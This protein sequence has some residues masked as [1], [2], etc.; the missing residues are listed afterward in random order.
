MG[1]ETGPSGMAGGGERDGGEARMLGT[2]LPALPSENGQ[3]RMQYLR[4]RQLTKEQTKHAQSPGC[5]FMGPLDPVFTTGGSCRFWLY[6]G[7][8]C[9]GMGYMLE[10]SCA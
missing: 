9:P 5:A 2:L 8:T 7:W 3:H 1:A 10:R 6:A 4:R